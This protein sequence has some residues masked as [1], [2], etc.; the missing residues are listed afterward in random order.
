ML[1]FKCFVGERGG[2]E[3]KRSMLRRGG[4]VRKG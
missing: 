1:V 2:E 3:K 4:K